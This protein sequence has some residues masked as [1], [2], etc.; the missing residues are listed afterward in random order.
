MVTYQCHIQARCDLQFRFKTNCKQIRLIQVRKHCLFIR[1]A[2]I[3]NGLCNYSGKIGV[4]YRFTFYGWTGKSLAVF[5]A[6]QK[7]A[8]RRRLRAVKRFRQLK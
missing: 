1:F 4:L 3:T 7:P 6:C 5:A 8:P 2:L